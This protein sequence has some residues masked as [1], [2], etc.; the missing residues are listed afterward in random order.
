MKSEL[1]EYREQLSGLARH[2]FLLEEERHS[3]NLLLSIKISPSFDDTFLCTV[4]KDA[5]LHV[6][7]WHQLSDFESEP[8]VKQLI[9]MR[10]GL[11]YS[12]KPSFSRNSLELDKADYLPLTKDLSKIRIPIYSDRE[13][14]Y[15]LDGTFYTLKTGMGASFSWWEEVADEWEPLKVL[16]Q[17]VLNL[18]SL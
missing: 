10:S 8:T 18:A 1:Q 16:A 7:V 11:D 12:I 13:T 15:G 9:Q 5:K 6:L 14:L 4:T 2:E 17:R 3:Q